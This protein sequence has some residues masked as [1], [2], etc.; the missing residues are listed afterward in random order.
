[1]VASLRNAVPEILCSD[2]V[3][4]NAA[5]SA[6]AHREVR[7]FVPPAMFAVAALVLGLTTGPVLAQDVAAGREK[8][9]VCVAC[10]GTDGVSVNREWPNLAGQQYDYMVKH[11]RKFR[12]G[13]RNDPL[14]EP[15]AR[16][17]TDTDINDLAAYFAALRR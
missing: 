9:A 12:D 2:N 4:M 16:T 1:M 6:L 11:L 14:M 15:V 7:L 5:V 10:H 17:L 8:S 3:D 13:I